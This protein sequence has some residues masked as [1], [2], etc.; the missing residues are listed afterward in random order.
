MA[1]ARR[2]H[3]RGAPRLPEAL[4]SCRRLDL[5]LPFECTLKTWLVQGLVAFSA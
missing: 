3:T 4:P 2:W 5:S 1:T